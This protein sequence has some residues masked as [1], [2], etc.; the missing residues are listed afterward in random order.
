MKDA[1][2]SLGTKVEAVVFDFDGTIADTRSL[3]LS[4]FR[5]AYDR[6]GLETPSDERIGSTIG[7]PLER[8]FRE[9]SGLSEDEGR[10]AAE[11]YRTVFRSLGVAQ[12]EAIGGMPLVVGRCAQ[13]GYRL[14]V[15][16]SRGH[17]SLQALLPALRLSQYLEVVAGREDAARE[18]PDPALLLSVAGALG[19]P[20][21]ELLMVGDTRFDLEMGRAAG[22]ATVGVTWGNHTRAEL[23]SADPTAIIE[24]PLELLKLLGL[25]EESP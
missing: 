11:A 16:S 25:S 19:L 24:D 7:L 17:E 4:C 6:L 15:A 8:A 10:R 23:E 12:V 20:P 3:I 21:D 22:S 1:S 13:A 18:K 5:A 9:L 14:A 2:L